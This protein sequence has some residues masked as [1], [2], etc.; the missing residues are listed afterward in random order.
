MTAFWGCEKINFA[1]YGGKILFFQRR[2]F[3][4]FASQNRWKHASEKYY[5]AAQT[6]K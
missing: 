6:A 5:L 2:V 1:A 3:N 4:D